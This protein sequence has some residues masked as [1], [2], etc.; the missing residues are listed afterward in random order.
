MD[1][2]LKISHNVISLGEVG[3]NKPEL[4]NLKTIKPSTK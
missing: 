1:A 2:L 3:K 4:S